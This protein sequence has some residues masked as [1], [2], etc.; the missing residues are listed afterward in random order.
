LKC[1][2]EC[3]LLHCR[4]SQLGRIGS[5]DNKVLQWPSNDLLF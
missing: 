5:G 2:P 4:Q 1:V 3:E